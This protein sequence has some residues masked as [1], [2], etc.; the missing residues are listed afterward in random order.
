VT[1]LLLINPRSGSGGPT[2]DDLADAARGR[3][4]DVRVLRE[5]DDAGELARSSGAEVLGMAGGDGSLAPVAAAALELG[6]TFVCIP[7]G[8]RNHFA[9]D[10]GLDRDDPLAALAAFD[11]GQ[12]QRVDVGRVG[13]R[14]F[15]NNVSLGL[16]AQLVH[17]REHHRRRR[18]AFARVRALALT[19]R[20]RGRTQRFTIDGQAV[21]AS[22]VL[23]AN[24]AYAFDVLSIGERDR[25][26]EGRLHLYVPH[27]LRRVTWEE[28]S[29]TEL[30]IDTD[31]HRVQAAID[32]EPVELDTPL[33]LRVEPAALRLLVPRG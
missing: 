27:G 13:D 17:E 3:G 22:V 18:N 20:D 26:D 12:V 19:L 29:C 28:R 24:N 11:D 15:L 21:R 10:A 14:L 8:T 23:V 2:A 31:G 7:F 32:G 25:L 33:E 16:Y 6:A 30:T 4:V 1:A 9:R 5:G